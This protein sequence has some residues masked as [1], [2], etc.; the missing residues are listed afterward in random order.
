[1]RLFFRAFGFQTASC[2]RMTSASMNPAPQGI[3]F[4]ILAPLHLSS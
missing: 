3:Q 1:M 2:Q 4:A